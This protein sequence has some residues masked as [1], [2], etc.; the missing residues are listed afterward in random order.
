MS[1]KFVIAHLYPDLMNLYGDRGNLLCLQ[2]RIRGYGYACEIRSLSLHDIVDFH[3]LDMVFIGG[4]SDREQGLVYND[5]LAKAEN[6]QQE[7][8]G[9]LPALFICGAFQLLGRYYQAP[10]GKQLQG[11]GFFDF[12][13]EGRSPRLIG[14][15][16]LES[17]MEGEKISVVGFENHGG[18]T[19]LH[20]PDLKP[21]GTVVK[22]YGNNGEDNGEG[23]W[24]KNLIA[25]YLHG[26]LLPKNPK[27][28]DYYIKAMAARRGL[29]LT[30]TL[31]DSIENFAHQQVR[32]KIQR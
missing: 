23:L 27:I 22:G 9:G 11:L 32:N 25:T 13:S 2:Q 17:E 3:H 10:D 7:I 16:L 21:F 28:A 26:P 30:L 15:I 6:L 12:H 8:E 5:L 24:Y 29:T 4:G 1:E 14:D 20:D 18:R 19:Y 31:D